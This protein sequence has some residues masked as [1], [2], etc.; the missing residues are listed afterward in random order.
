MLLKNE[1]KYTTLLQKNRFYPFVINNVSM[2]KNPTDKIFYYFFK[3]FLIF[4]CFFFLCAELLL[5][6][7]SLHLGT[8]RIYLMENTDNKVIEEKNEPENSEV[9]DSGEVV[10]P[11]NETP[12]KAAETPAEE[13]DKAKFDEVFASLQKVKDDNGLIEV[14]V[15][16]KIRGGLRVSYQEM[17]MFLPAAHFALKRGDNEEA[18]EKAVGQKF[19]VALLELQEDETK[20][21]TVVVTRRAALEQEFWSGIE[22]G[23]TV[24]G[25]VSSIADFGVFLDLGGFEGLIHISQLS[26]TH[27]SN[28]KEFT[29]IGEEM[30]AKIIK[31]EK[32]KKK[33]SLSHKEFTPSP[34]AGIAEKY[35]AGSKVKGIVRRFVSF[36]TFVELEP[37]IDGLL[38]SQ[39]LSWTKRVNSAQEILTKNQEIE[40]VVI[41]VDE[42]HQK[43]SLSLRQAQEDPWATMAEKY[44]TNTALKGK[45]NNVV[46]Q[47]VVVTVDDTIDGFIPKSRFANVPR[48]VKLPF[49]PGEELDV[50]VE[51][52][53]AEKHSMILK[54]ATD[55]LFADMEFE[56]PE[57]A[58]DNRDSGDRRR[59]QRRDNRDRGTRIDKAFQAQKG[60]SSFSIADL[61]PDNLKSNLSK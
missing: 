18:M 52:I 4:F 56:V 44:P 58:E 26:H 1:Q 23:Q 19:N 30:E 31:I 24:K 51:E 15:L 17:P 13:M 10:E 28:P 25:K 20:R 49:K 29:K 27:I 2:K 59:D 5:I 38:R 33:I 46:D 7:N 43:V 60:G 54:P 47:G 45:V 57:G 61:L 6:L 12:E 40:V 11:S 22:E 42:E 48:G 14:E 16:A 55:N 41:S 53:N 36:G 34:W 9:K 39:E 35:A 37:G 32:D 50:L 3:F 21:K 8:N